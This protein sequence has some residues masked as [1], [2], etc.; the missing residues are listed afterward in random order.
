MAFTAASS[1][2]FSGI[3]VS[4]TD[5]VIPLASING[6]AS[7]DATGD[8]RKLLQAILEQYAGWYEALATADK[9]AKLSVTKSTSLNGSGVA[10]IRFSSEFS[11]TLPTFTLGSET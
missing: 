2:V 1:A 9:P 4:G 3:N 11:G 10:K 8:S 7:A 5:L 6:I